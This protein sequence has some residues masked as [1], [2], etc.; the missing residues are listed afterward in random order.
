M[1][2][3][4]RPLV[5]TGPARPPEALTLAGGFCWFTHAEEITRDGSSRFVSADDLPE[6][7]RH[8]L[9][10]PRAPIAGISFERPR[11]MGILNVTPDSF[12]DGGEHESAGAALA[13]AKTIAAQGADIIDVGGESTRPGAKTVPFE[14]EIAR[15]EPVI[16]A[17]R[18]E[19]AVPISID[20]RKAAVARAA[21]EAGAGLVNDV[22]GFT[23][24]KALA[25]YCLA[26]DLPI[27]VMH[28]R[29]DPETM[30]LDPRYD[31]VLL[32]VYDFLAAQVIL[33]TGLGIPRSQIIVDPGIGFGK[34]IEHNL[35]LLSGI[36]LFHGLGCPVL[37][38]AS[39][40]AFIRTLSAASEPKERMPGSVA[41][42][43]GAVAQG[44]QICRVHDVKE[45]GQA[46]ALW[47]A[48][49]RKGAR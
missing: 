34:T 40:K 16:A 36:S 23:F 13:H 27:C 26:H 39:R 21:H 14:S 24:D 25:P 45:T 44:V 41:V 20:T 35:R 18:Y 5:Q 8:L 47:N 38:G 7:I 48:V 9:T 17:I 46:F 1:S 37:L 10:A 42:A 33:L 32:D 31:D 28:A 19:L 29:G 6:D 11:I 15:I 30:H 49:T 22:S 4:F 3:Y 43:L 12:S 2:V